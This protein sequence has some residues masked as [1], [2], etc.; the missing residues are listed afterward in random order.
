MQNWEKRNCMVIVRS[1][2]DPGAVVNLLLQPATDQNCKTSGKFVEIFL[3][4]TSPTTTP[5][6]RQPLQVTK[7]EAFDYAD[8]FKL[9]ATK[10]ENM[11]YD[12]K[13]IEEWCLNN[14]MTLNEN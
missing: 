4:G 3:K 8:D 11:Q 5:T 13:Q 2:R 6:K 1:Q 7:C 12:I 9:V 10:S 14:K